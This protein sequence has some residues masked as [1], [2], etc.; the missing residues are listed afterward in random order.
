MSNP[1][2]GSIDYVHVQETH[3][4]GNP[5]GCL[6][7]D[8]VGFQQLVTGLNQPS[9]IHYCFD[10]KKLYVCETDRILV[11]DINQDEDGLVS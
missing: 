4:N 10:M 2:D 9:Y 7:A 8:Q 5:H 3:L 1:D 11:Y 6:A